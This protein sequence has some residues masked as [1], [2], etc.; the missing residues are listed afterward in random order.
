M[1]SLG[2]HLVRKQIPVMVM[3]KGMGPAPLDSLCP[4]PAF[5]L[6]VHLQAVH[7]ALCMGLNP[8]LFHMENR[9]PGTLAA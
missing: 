6:V 9:H 5:I 2:G 1:L 8:E 3:C 4:F 7:R